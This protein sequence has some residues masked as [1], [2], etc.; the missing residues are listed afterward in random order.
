MRKAQFV[1]LALPVLGLERLGVRVVAGFVLEEQ[2]PPALFAARRVIPDDDRR[3]GRPAIVNGRLAARDFQVRIVIARRLIGAE[4]PFGHR[5]PLPHVGDRGAGH[6]N[7]TDLGVVHQ[8]LEDTA[9]VS[10]S[11]HDQTNLLGVLDTRLPAQPPEFFGHHE[12]RLAQR[13]SGCSNDHPDEA[14]QVEVERRI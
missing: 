5:F 9:F 6:R 14:A 8:P 3:H 4:E 7:E 1:I 2:D 12:H 13:F 10:A 11:V